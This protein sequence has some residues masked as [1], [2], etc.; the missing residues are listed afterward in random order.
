[1]STSAITARISRFNDLAI[2]I[3]YY[4]VAAICVLG[5]LLTMQD[6]FSKSTS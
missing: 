3:Y 1:M 5:L 6:F 4:A 2:A